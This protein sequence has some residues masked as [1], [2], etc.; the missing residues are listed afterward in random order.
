M[1]I[2]PQTEEV[3]KMVIAAGGAPVNL[4]V[5]DWYTSLEKG[6]TE[7]FINAFG[8]KMAFK[9]MELLR[10]HTLANPGGFSMNPHLILINPE[11][12]KR[13]PPDIQKV[14]KDNE[15]FYIEQC[16]NGVV[17]E[18]KAA[19]AYAEKHGHTIVS[20]TPDEM[21]LWQKLAQPVHDEWISKNASKGGK[22]IYA[23]IKRLISEYKGK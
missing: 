15:Q 20:L 12:W 22:E 17:G 13:I 21:K 2:T 19:L 5:S 11:N 14:L 9:I 8:A 10:F 18:E 7:G 16:I 3:A 23:E 6:V 1:K 4:V